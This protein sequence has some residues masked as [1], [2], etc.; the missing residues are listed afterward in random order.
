MARPE[1]NYVQL[2]LMKKKTNE[3]F[4]CPKSLYALKK[5]YEKGA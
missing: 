2:C 5:M 3:K 1:S 4:K